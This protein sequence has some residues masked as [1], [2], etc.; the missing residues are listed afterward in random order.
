[1]AIPQTGLRGLSSSWGANL[2]TANIKDGSQEKPG[3]WKAMTLPGEDGSLP[4]E[5]RNGQI[6]FSHLKISTEDF[7]ERYGDN[8]PFTPSFSLFAC[9]FGIV[10]KIILSVEGKIHP[11][12]R[13]PT[14][15]FHYSEKLYIFPFT[16]HGHQGQQI[17]WKN[18]SFHT[19]LTAGVPASKFPFWILKL[20][21]GL[22]T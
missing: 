6:M 9:P 15:L 20:Q 8:N 7:S 12:R 3:S 17:P 18:N 19:S 1:M 22:T 13:L 16:F 11:C 4:S 14:L 21:R 10:S 2:S 5:R